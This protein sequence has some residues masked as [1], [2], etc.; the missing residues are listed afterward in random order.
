MKAMDRWLR[1]KPVTAD[2]LAERIE[3]LNG[4][5]RQEDAARA[6]GM[7]PKMLFLRC[8]KFGIRWKKHIHDRP[9]LRRNTVSYQGEIVSLVRLSRLTG[10]SRNA[11]RKRYER[12]LRG[13]GL[14]AKSRQARVYEVS[15]TA[16][17]VNQIVKDYREGPASRTKDP[18]RSLAWHWKL[19]KGAVSA[20]IKHQWHRLIWVD[21]QEAA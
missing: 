19:P 2:P 10:V 15:L 4:T 12:G 20:L 3:A 18:I 5:M 6:L 21:R 1:G 17:Q 8:R 14:V 11:L 16:E 13:V 9:D 7:T